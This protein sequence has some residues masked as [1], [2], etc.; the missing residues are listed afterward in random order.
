MRVLTGLLLSTGLAGSIRW[1]SALPQVEMI[2]LRVLCF[3]AVIA[4]A[5]AVALIGLS[6]RDRTRE[7]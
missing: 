3:S 7:D 2:V 4:L 6:L 5:C 1:A